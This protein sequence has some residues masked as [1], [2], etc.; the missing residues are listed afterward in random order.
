MYKNKTLL[1]IIPARSGSKGLKDKNIKLLNGIP[2]LAHSVIQAKE[3]SVVDYIFL[4]TDSVK[5]KNIGLEYGAEVPYLRP[6][7]LATDT[8]QANDYIINALLYFKDKFDYFILLQPTSPLRCAKDI[9]NVFMLAVDNDYSS[10]VSVCK[11]D[12]P[13]EYYNTLDENMSMYNFIG[14]NKNRQDLK[15]YYRVNGAIYL[16]KC[17]EF[18]K[19][20]TFYGVNSK[21][22]IMDRKFSVDIDNDFDFSL[23]ALIMEKYKNDR[24]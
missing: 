17:N 11:A 10:V 4:S 23:A 22:Y 9:E 19:D 24:I 21:A 18:L 6:K 2:L 12:H 7:E 14:D 15:Q 13:I 3:S 20:R 16:C 8:S 5:Y 1:A